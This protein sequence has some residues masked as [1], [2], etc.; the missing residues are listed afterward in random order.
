MYNNVKQGC[1]EILSIYNVC[2][3]MY[4]SSVSLERKKKQSQQVRTGF[5]FRNQ[6]LEKTITKMRRREACKYECLIKSVFLLSFTC[7]FH[8]DM[9]RRIFA[10]VLFTRI[11][12]ARIQVNTYLNCIVEM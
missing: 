11:M 7:W 9:K 12:G 4:L 8:L 2:A 6:H 5:L 1:C 10:T 3:Y